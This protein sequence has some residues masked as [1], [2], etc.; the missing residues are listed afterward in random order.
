ML[1]D[2]NVILKKICDEEAEF[3]CHIGK[4]SFKDYGSY[5]TQWLLFEV[6]TFGRHLGGSVG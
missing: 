1:E 5:K 3:E 4:R 2:N 6:F